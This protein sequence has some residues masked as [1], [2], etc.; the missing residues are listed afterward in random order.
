MELQFRKAVR[1]AVPQIISISG[2]SGSGKTYSALLLA[3]GLVKPGGTVALLDTENGRGQMYADSPGITAA[4][5]Q[6]FGYARMDPPFSP[7][8]YIEAIDAAEKAGVEVLVIDSG[9]HEWEG[10]G[11]CTEMAEKDKGRWNRAK[12]E[13]RRF[14]YRLLYSN[15]HIV[16]C[17]R[18][19]EK[20]KIVPKHKSETGK[21][22]VISLG[23]LPVCEKN[24]VFEML[25]S[26]QLD[27]QT[28]HASPVKVP[29][30]LLALFPGSRMLV[31]ADGERIRQWNESGAAAEPLE[32]IV[33]RGR[34]AAELGTEEYRKF[35]TSLTAAQRK[36]FSDVSHAENKGIAA[37]ADKANEVPVF[38]S[39]ETPV[40]WPDSFDGPE[41]VWNG[42]R[43]RF[44]EAAGNY[45][46]EVK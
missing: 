22:E 11:G 16:V 8:R 25:L 20:S 27:E 2:T 9:S 41:C 6:G 19:R 4:L 23:I 39:A 38:G 3:A 28:H 5:P 43:L 18:A 30:P 46:E 29:E 35:W 7:A 34:A 31:K 10:Y 37:A 14:V 40:A 44:D 21:E 42:K 1:A 12:L 13:N 36:V 15:M 33:Q 24:F 26:M 45:V 32:R 17:L